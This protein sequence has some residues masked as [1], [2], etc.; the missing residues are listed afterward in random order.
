MK[1]EAKKCFIFLV[2]YTTLFSALHSEPRPQT[3]EFAFFYFSLLPNYHCDYIEIIN[4]IIIKTLI[5]NGPP[6]LFHS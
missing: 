3:F 6:H 5:E 2:C 4:P 1:K